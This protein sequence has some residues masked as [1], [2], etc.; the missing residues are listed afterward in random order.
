MG[1][2]PNPENQARQDQALAWLREHGIASTG[3]IA[4][5]V[6]MVPSG[7]WRPRCQRTRGAWGCREHCPREWVSNGRSYGDTANTRAA[8]IRLERMGLV[9]RVDVPESRKSWWRAGNLDDELVRL[10]EAEA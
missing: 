5:A 10:L 8:L 9:D 4:E 6:W 7:Y 3:E 1:R 2:G